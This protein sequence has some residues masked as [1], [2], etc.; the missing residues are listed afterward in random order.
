MVNI[1]FIC[2]KI[3][4]FSFIRKCVDF[5]FIK[6]AVII[7]AMMIRA[8]IHNILW[9]VLSSSRSLNYMSYFN[10]ASKTT[11]KAIIR[12]FEP[13]KGIISNLIAMGST[14][15]PS[16]IK[17]F[18]RTIQCTMCRQFSSTFNFKFSATNFTNTLYDIRLSVFSQSETMPFVVA[19]QRTK[20]SLMH[21]SRLISERIT[22]CKAFRLFN[23]HSLILTKS[24][25][26]VHD[27]WH[28]IGA[29]LKE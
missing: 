9:L 7:K 19:F 23:N 16:F 27:H 10:K 3:M 21:T 6:Q 13:H 22:A 26:Y 24:P 12:M 25:E 17:T 28:L 18:T 11:N 8:K 5:V 15:T 2:F 1:N 14:S 20:S 29:R 4:F